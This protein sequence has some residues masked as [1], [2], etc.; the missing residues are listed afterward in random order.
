MHYEEM[1]QDLKAILR[2]ALAVRFT[3]LVIC[4]SGNEHGKY[5]AA[6]TVRNKFI[7]G[8]NKAQRRTNNRH[9]LELRPA[10]IARVR[11]Y[12]EAPETGTM[13]FLVI[14]HNQDWP[15]YRTEVGITAANT[16]FIGRLKA[17]ETGPN[18]RHRPNRDR[19]A[20]ADSECWNGDNRGKA[21]FNE[22]DVFTCG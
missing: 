12:G 17:V 4:N 8:S 19:Q 11:T 16:N 10:I 13:G 2:P 3:P 15:G 9:L 14:K 22:I 20:S 5:N 21:D 6:R 7:V 1:W 18:F